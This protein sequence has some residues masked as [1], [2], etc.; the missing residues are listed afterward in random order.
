[1][2]SSFQTLTPRGKQEAPAQALTSQPHSNQSKP[3]Y[4][5][6]QEPEAS[7]KRHLNEPLRGDKAAALPLQSRLFCQPYCSETQIFTCFVL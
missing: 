5:M 3:D 2:V 7:V 6:Q 4:Q 1:M